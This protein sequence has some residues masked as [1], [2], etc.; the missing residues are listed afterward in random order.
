MS[1][2]LELGRGLKDV[3]QFAKGLLTILLA[4]APDGRDEA[5]LQVVLQSLSSASVGSSSP[6]PS[7][8]DLLAHR[9]QHQACQS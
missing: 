5:R 1:G 2:P 6:S 4:V 8:G 3:Q 9:G 7:G